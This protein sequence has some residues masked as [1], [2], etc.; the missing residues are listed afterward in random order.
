MKRKY[1]GSIYLKNSPREVSPPE[2]KE[3][4]DSGWQRIFEYQRSSKT[5]HQD[6]YSNKTANGA[7]VKAFDKDEGREA[8]AKRV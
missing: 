1:T 3:E 4:S 6:N 7:T 2:K 8:R 5:F